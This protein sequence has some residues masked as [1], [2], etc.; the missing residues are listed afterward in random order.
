MASSIIISARPRTFNH[1]AYQNIYL[2]ESYTA[3]LSS[4][5]AL[6]TH[7][8]P[9]HRPNLRTM[10]QH[11]LRR[12]LLFPSNPLPHRSLLR[13]PCRRY[14][15]PL[16][17][18]TLSF[19]PIHFRTSPFRPSCASPRRSCLHR[20][21]R[22]LLLDLRPYFRVYRILVSC[23]A[24]ILDAKGCHG[25]VDKVHGPPGLDGGYWPLV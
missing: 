22:A 13:C 9:H 24:Y 17:P 14:I 2:R 23:T 7:R 12:N 8:R 18:K 21:T 10:S 16:H 25:R 3:F 5:L 6:S 1:H 11:P 4:S 15:A 20:R 19:S